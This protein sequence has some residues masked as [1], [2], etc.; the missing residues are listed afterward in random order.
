[1]RREVTKRYAGEGAGDAE[2]DGSQPPSP[3][4]EAELPLRGG[5]GGATRAGGAQLF[6]GEPDQVLDASTRGG[7]TRSSGDRALSPGARPAGGGGGDRPHRAGE[8]PDTGPENDE[9][10]PFSASDALYEGVVGF[11]GAQ[12]AAG[13]TH[14]ELG[15]RLNVD[16]RELLRQLYQDHL[17]LRAVHET[18]AVEVRDAHER[19]HGAVEA[20]HERPLTTIFGSAKVTRFAYRRRGEENL[21]LQDAALNLPEEVHSHG[22][23]ELAAIESS[24]GSYEE[25]KAAIGRATGLNLGK[26]QVEEL[27]ARAAVDVEDFYDRAKPEPAGDTDA[28]VISCDGKGIVMRPGELREATKKA[29]EASRHKLE[30]R[31]TRGE[32]KDRKRMAELA[33]VY[34]CPLVARSPAD[35]M[36]RSEDGAKPPAPPAK[37]KW[38]TAS[39]AED[40]K[41]V[42]AAAFCEAERRDPGHLRP[43]VAL[44][45]GNRHQIDRIKA[46]ANKRGIDITIVVNWIHVVEYLW[47]AARCFFAETDPEGEAFVAEKALAILEGKAGV[48]AGSI[49]RKATMVHLNAKAREKADECA[50]YLRNK[51]PYLDYPKA[52]AAGWP[53]LTDRH[54]CDRRRLRPFG[55]RQDGRDRGT[56]VRCRCGGD[57]E[58]T[59]GALERRL[60][61]VLLLPLGTRARAR[62][63]VSLCRRGY[64]EGRLIGPSSGATPNPDSSANQRLPGSIA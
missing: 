26:R 22:L 43:W 31:L 9:P 45:D 18:R 32:K 40:A 53:L 44:V 2:G 54:G 1:M 28:L 19:F 34:D 29:A 11:L 55:P 62:S 35:V 59:S 58:T 51:K 37:A 46:E 21:Y 3:L 25:A 14:S 13:L 30:A 6:P 50:R 17:D 48:V 20:N 33:V 5:R 23:R 57:P 27:T 10:N 64:P 41:E 60:V 47:S 39:V 56:L 15:A 61:R 38:L 12:E 16:D 4:R 24:R 42:I 49:L 52:L 8:Q 63:R 7:G 36:A